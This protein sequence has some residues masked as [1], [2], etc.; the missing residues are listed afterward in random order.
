MNTS[1]ASLKSA[2]SHSRLALLSIAALLFVAVLFGVVMTSGAQAATTYS[3]EEAAFVNMLNDYRAANGLAPLLV[4]DL[5]SEACYRH[6]HDMAKYAFFDHT[7]LHSDWF[8]V[9]ALPWDRMAA[10]GYN[11]YTSKGENIAAGQAT[12]ADVFTAWKNSPGHNANMLNA[13][14][15]VLGV[16]QYQL[17][18]SPYTFYW[19]TD[20]G[21]YVDPTAHAVSSVPTPTTS[22]FEQNNSKLGYTGAWSTSSGSN[23]S[24]GSYTY[25]NAPASV[26]VKFVGTYLAYIAKKGPSYGLVKITLDGGTPVSIDLYNGST[27]YQQKIWN[28]GVL[29]NGSHTVKLEWAGVRRAAATACN[30]G[31]DAFDIAGTLD[32]TTGTPTTTRYQQTDSHF[33]YSGTWS[34]FSTTSSSGGSYSRTAAT[35]STVTASFNGTYFKWIAT[36]GTTMGKAYVSL[37]G[38]TAQL[39]DLAYTSAQYQQEVWSTGVLVSGP[40]TVKI[41]WYP[42]NASGKYI[43]ID[44]FDVAGTLLMP[45]ST[46]GSQSTRYEQTDSHLVWAGTW[47]TY[48][49]ASASNGSYKRAK[50][51]GSSVTVN[52]TG[53]HLS[54][55]ATAGTTL[56]KAYV[57][58]DGGA[59]VSIDLA[60]TAVAYQQSVCNTGTLANGRHTV[61][62]WWDPSNATGKYIS[63]DAFVIEGTLN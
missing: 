2:H 26:T 9:N 13:A 61:K 14:Y 63:V 6:N 19:T 54:W 20:F 5:I 55:I 23:E 24:G 46:V 36:K 18:G 60:R 10:S 62:I 35:G 30:V 42:S 12:A 7:S 58:L 45:T 32:G 40:H 29:A 25:V 28:T 4:S 44:A 41:T 33:V 53:T 31:L 22:R 43:N 15:T 57:S 52:F 38:G 17:A 56:S 3:N 8:A 59:A 16:S 37:D 34:T 48:A 11:F 27:L 21:G 1:T 39:V 49:T 50:T 51:S 47:A